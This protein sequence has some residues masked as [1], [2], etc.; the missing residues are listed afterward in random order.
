MALHGGKT[1]PPQHK[2]AQVNAVKGDE[3]GARQQLF[4]DV[5]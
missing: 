4:N 2:N 5:K 1:L 3:A